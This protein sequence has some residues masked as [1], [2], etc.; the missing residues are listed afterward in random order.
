MSL[1][2]TFN[3]AVLGSWLDS[4]EIAIETIPLE[5]KCSKCNKLYFPKKENGYKSPCCNFNLEEIISGRELKI[6][7]IDFKEK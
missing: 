5:G 6:A 7:S 4:S 3:A 2:N 1:I